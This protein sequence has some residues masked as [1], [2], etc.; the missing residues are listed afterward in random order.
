[1]KHTLTVTLF[2]F[3]SLISAFAVKTEQA[4]FDGFAAFA[5]GTFENVS[6]SH[7]GEL[8]AAPALTQ[9][10]ALDDARAIFDAVYVDGDLYVATGNQG[11]VFHIDSTGEVELFFESNQLMARALA[12]GPDGALYVGTAPEGSVYRI[13][14]GQRAE[15]Y[16]DSED[17][18]IWDLHFDTAGNLFVATGQKAAIYKLPRDYDSKSRP[19]PWFSCD[20]VHIQVMTP[21]PEGGWLIGASP[22]AYLYRVDAEGKG[23]LLTQGNG[24]EITAIHPEGAD[25]YFSTFGGETAAI[26]STGNGAAPSGPPTPPRPQAG[27]SSSSGGKNTPLYKLTAEGFVEGVTDFPEAN[28]FT[29]LPRSDAPWLVGSDAESRLFSFSGTED[30]ALLQQIKDGGQVSVFVEGGDKTFVLTSNPAAVYTLGNSPEKATYTSTPFDAKQPAR[31]GAMRPLFAE[32]GAEGFSLFAP[33]V[34]VADEDKSANIDAAPSDESE[35]D[36]KPE[37]ETTATPSVPW[38]FETRSGNA[39]TPDA[40]WSEWMAVDSDLKVTSPVGRYLQWRLTLNAPEALLLTQELFYQYNNTA[41]QI[42]L[43]RFLPFAV[44]VLTARSQQ[45]PI[46][47]QQ[48][49][50]KSKNNGGGESNIPEPQERQ[51]LIPQGQRGWMTAVW[52]AQDPNG[53]TLRYAVALATASTLAQGAWLT[54]ATDLVDPVYSFNTIGLESGYYRLRVEASDHL[55]NAPETVRKGTKISDLFL[56]DNDAPVVTA[57]IETTSSSLS[58][59]WQVMDALSV[60]STASYTHNGSESLDLLPEDGLFDAQQEQFALSLNGLVPGEHSIAF[61]ARDAAGNETRWQQIVRVK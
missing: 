49:L 15:V 43:I 55:S 11:K 44:D 59:R 12:W 4:R 17:S 2:V 13:V 26:P 6:L 36:K 31:W 54:L 10:G 24:S 16:F 30:W 7:L 37:A 8:S 52:R 45:P 51:Q 34:V 38:A 58:I 20:R 60:V 14:P 18:Y 21:H 23:T 53:D 1:M 5:G 28:I 40:T 48:L 39:P 32:V 61:V 33:R 22:D 19:K 9:L 29:F 41:P 35:S 47:L 46:H 50:G 42:S 57:E 56:I 27:S 3:S 25:I